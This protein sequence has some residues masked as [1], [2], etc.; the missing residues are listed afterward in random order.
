MPAYYIGAD[1]LND[2]PLKA[3]LGPRLRRVWAGGWAYT[4]DESLEQVSKALVNSQLT[5]AVVFPFEAGHQ[6]VGADQSGMILNEVI[7]G[8]YPT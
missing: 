7:E 6:M 3:A 1:P 2:A 4:T 8:A 5:S